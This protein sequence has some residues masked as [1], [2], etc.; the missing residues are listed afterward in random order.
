MDYLSNPKLKRRAQALRRAATPDENT[1]WYQYLRQH[2]LQFR[3]QKPIGAYIVDFYCHRA[4]LVIELDGSQHFENAGLE[5]DAQRTAYPESLGLLVIRI[6]NNEV[7][8]NLRGVC[9]YI[10]HILASRT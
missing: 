6:P 10:D 4:K 9:E 7:K 1:L 5:Y 8:R 3:R 2:P